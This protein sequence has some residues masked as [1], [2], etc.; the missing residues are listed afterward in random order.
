MIV[1][2]FGAGFLAA[3]ALGSVTLLLIIDIRRQIVRNRIL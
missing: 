3:A 2:G 1:L